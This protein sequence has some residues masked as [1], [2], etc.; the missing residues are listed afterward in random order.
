M[1]RVPEG[2]ELFLLTE[3]KEA[4]IKGFQC[5]CLLYS[6]L[7][8]VSFPSS[9]PTSGNPTFQRSSS[10]GL[11]SKYPPAT[12]LPSIWSTT[13]HHPQPLF[14]R[15]DLRHTFECTSPFP[16]FTILETRPRSVVALLCHERE[17]E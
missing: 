12:N 1:S 4:G 17:N 15:L 11:F 14:P 5:A 10:F 6:A 9:A 3:D 16:S 8:F 13:S 7:L 2:V